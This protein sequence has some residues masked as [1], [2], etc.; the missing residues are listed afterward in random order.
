MCRKV[1]LVEYRESAAGGRRETDL[2]SGLPPWS[3]L[4]HGDAVSRHPNLNA[5]SEGRGQFINGAGFLRL[6][7]ED[8]DASCRTRQA[9]L[10]LVFTHNSREGKVFKQ[11]L[12][13][14]GLALRP[15]TEAESVLGVQ[16]A[17]QPCNFVCF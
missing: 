5:R 4:L 11:R 12:G 14:G 3:R 1:S 10:L 6:L 13:A 17:T 7:A 9:V 16:G 8:R 15:K 2:S